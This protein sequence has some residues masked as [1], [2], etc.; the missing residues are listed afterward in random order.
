[1]KMFS[2]IIVAMVTP[3]EDDESVSTTRTAKLLDTLL[4]Q[5]VAGIFILG[6]NGEAYAMS[7]DEKFEFAKFVIGYVNKR[8]KIIVGTGLETTRGTIAFSQRIAVLRPDALSLITPSFMPPSQDELIGHYQAIASAVDIPCILYNMPGKTGINIDPASIAVLSR[9]PNIIGLKDSSGKLD[10]FQGYL[11]NRADD[12]FELIMGSDGRIL[13]SLEMG[14]DAA[15]AGTGNLLTANLVR[16]YKAFKAGDMAVAQEC[17]DNIQ[18][19]RE[20]LHAATVPVSLKAAVSESGV[21]VG[22]ARRPALMPKPGSDLAGRIS[23][24]VEQYRLTHVI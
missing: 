14:G 3:F 1:M 16:L 2:G 19:L 15:I 8:T 20:V 12:D 4:E 13:Q 17:Q 7:E 9:H 10:N 21:N 24:V 23:Q 18:P 6:T 22:P 5:D 11:D